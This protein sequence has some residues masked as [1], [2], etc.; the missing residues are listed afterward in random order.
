MLF[1]KT[2]PS[3]F[4]VNNVSK[5][6]RFHEVSNPGHLKRCPSYIPKSGA[7]VRVCEERLASP[8][9]IGPTWQGT[10][11]HGVMPA[12][13]A[14]S[15]AWHKGMTTMMRFLCGV[16]PIHVP[17]VQHGNLQHASPHTTPT[18]TPR[19]TTQS[20]T[21]RIPGLHRR[22]VTI[23]DTRPYHSVGSHGWGRGSSCR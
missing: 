11:R 16:G 7:C 4:L 18:S 5:L 10:A 20:L 12:K 21:A 2:I 6:E 14:N 17:V 19:H 13:F 8:P 22:G 23:A 3:K 9:P 15:T 1:F